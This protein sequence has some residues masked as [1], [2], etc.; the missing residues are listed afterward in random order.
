MFCTATT[1]LFFFVYLLF[2]RV[3][4]V[5]QPENMQKIA[6]VEN[7][8]SNKINWREDSD[9]GIC[10]YYEQKKIMKNTRTHSAIESWM[11]E[12]KQLD[13]TKCSSCT[14]SRLSCHIWSFVF[15]F[16]ILFI[17]FAHDYYAKTKKTYK[18]HDVRV[19]KHCTQVKWNTISGAI[20]L[21][22]RNTS[23]EY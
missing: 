5:T 6:K 12:S 14:K 4:A 18:M 3:F 7:K 22:S 19:Q 11:F 13:G 21:T 15:P 10:I 17:F 1:K 9:N 20:Q 16:S 23:L 8:P 2:S